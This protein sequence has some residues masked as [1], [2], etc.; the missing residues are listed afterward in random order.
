MNKNVFNITENKHGE[1]VYYPMQQQVNEC[2]IS[3]L[4]HDRDPP[5]FGFYLH[6]ELSSLYLFFL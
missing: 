1:M 4:Y 6:K 3:L 2:I 5:L